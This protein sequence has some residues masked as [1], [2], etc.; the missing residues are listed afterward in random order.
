MAYQQGCLRKSHRK[1]GEVWLLRY[2]TTKPDGSRV[3][4]THIVGAIS[5]FPKEADA[6]REVDR[7]GLLV[8]INTEDA[9]IGRIKFADLAEHYLKAD[10]GEDAA[11]PKSETTIP[12]VEHYV[13]HYL[14]PRWKDVI[15]EDIKPLDIQRW[16][17]SLNTRTEE[18][19]AWPTIAKIRAI[20]NRVYKVGLLHELVT[21]NPVA[22]TECRGKSDY[23]AI[24]ITPEQTLAI[25]QGMKSALHSALVLTCAA[26]ALRASEI[27][28]LR[29]SDVLWFENRIRISKRWAKGAD[30]KTK[31]ESSDDYVPVHSLLAGHLHDWQR[32]TPHAKETDFMFPSLTA[33]GRIPIC[34]CTFVADYLRPAAIAAGVVI[35]KGKR[36]GLHNLRHSLSNW[37]VSKAKT[38]PK[39][40]QGLL[41]HANVKTTLQLYARSDGDE[42]RAAQ[43]AFLGAVGILQI[44]QA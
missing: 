12:I 42:T 29:W 18:P 44:A 21:K 17:R 30:G 11:R 6:R 16:L 26:T 8:R 22:H 24:D 27:L 31:T 34:A 3:E 28:S 37:L 1:A 39:T 32:Q 4:N 43:G 7:L 15:A 9:Q 38:D 13:R 41:R 10:F 19:L 23:K 20:M 40:V 33:N 2:R 35:P 14:V 5:K 25:L 36:F